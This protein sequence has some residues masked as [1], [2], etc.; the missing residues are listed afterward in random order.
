VRSHLHWE[1]R[2]DWCPGKASA[3]TESTGSRQSTLFGLAPP[4]LV[5]PP[6][7]KGGGKKRKAAGTDGDDESQETQ[8]SRPKHDLKAAF[9]KAAARPPRPAPVASDD[10]VEETQ[11]V[12]QRVRLRSVESDL[13]C[14]QPEKRSK[15]DAVL[16]DEDP[17]FDAIMDALAA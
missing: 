13:T 14:T 6:P 11:L 4:K 16:E 3:A 5:D 17:E 12:E 1:H 2:A 9:A 10:E 8:S 15:L 7:K